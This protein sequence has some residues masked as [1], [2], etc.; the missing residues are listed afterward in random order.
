MSLG[1]PVIITHLIIPIT[2][3]CI[4]SSTVT[5]SFREWRVEGRPKCPGANSSNICEQH[6]KFLLLHSLYLNHFILNIFPIL[7]DSQVFPWGILGE[8]IQI[9][10]LWT[11]NSQVI[12]K[13]KLD[14]LRLNI[15][16][17]EQLDLTTNLD[18]LA[19]DVLSGKEVIEPEYK[20]V[21][22]HWFLQCLKLLWV[23]DCVLMVSIESI[24]MDGV[25]LN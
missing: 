12:M 16:W 6:G 21:M 13:K 18:T 25:R 15:E 23:A 11:P 19:A 4:I 3:R 7:N 10:N 20:V 17:I 2:E 1:K 14:E 8:I 24:W 5:S 22:F 9:F